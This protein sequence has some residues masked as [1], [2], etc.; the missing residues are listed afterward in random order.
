[1]MHLPIDDMSSEHFSKLLELFTEAMN[2]KRMPRELGTPE[3]IQAGLQLLILI[4]RRNS[5]IM[6]ALHQSGALTE[7]E[8]SDRLSPYEKS[9]QTIVRHDMIAKITNPEKKKHNWMN[10]KFLA[11]LSSV[12]PDGDYATAKTAKG[13]YDKHKNVY[14]NRLARM[15]RSPKVAVLSEKYPDIDVQKALSLGILSDK[16]DTTVDDLNFLDKLIGVLC[17]K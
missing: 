7:K 12:L 3:D 6:E 2:N 15:R 9:I 5:V 11:F 1:M 10:N 8:T 4:K 14:A 13:L 16:L 17:R